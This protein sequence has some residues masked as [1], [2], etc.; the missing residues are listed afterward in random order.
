MNTLEQTMIV[1]LGDRPNPVMEDFLAGCPHVRRWPRA[2]STR[3]IPD[4]RN[5]IVRWFMQRCTGLAFLLQLDDDMFPTTEGMEAL[6]ASEADVAGA[7]VL[8]DGPCGQKYQHDHQ[9]GFACPCVRLSRRALSVLG[10]SPFAN[11]YD[12][13]GRV[14]CCE[15]RNLWNTCMRLSKQ[16]HRWL[17]PAVLGTIR[18]P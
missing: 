12:R 15:C 4:A 7:A 16:Q 9:G 18:H 1:V 14:R 5:E 10:S 11:Q 17:Q 3:G 13:N 8:R 6:L 2:A